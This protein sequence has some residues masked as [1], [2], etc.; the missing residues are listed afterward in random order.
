MTN[1][2]THIYKISIKASHLDTFGHVNNAKYLE[3][4]EEARWDLIESRGYGMETIK[5]LGQGP[6]ILEINII[7]KKELKYKD[8]IEI[9]TTSEK[10]SRVLSTITHKMYNSAN[11]LCCEANYLIGLFDTKLRKLIPPTEEWLKVINPQ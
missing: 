6:T 7:Y 8:I 5:K 10:K 11:E 1:T 9:H 2:D 3:I 4:L